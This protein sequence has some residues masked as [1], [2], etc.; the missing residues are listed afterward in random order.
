MRNS[1][2]PDVAILA[3]GLGSRL[4]STIG[5][6]PK[7]LAPVCG[8]PFIEFVLNQLGGFGFTRI[9]L[10]C[11][12]RAEQI[13]NFLGHEYGGLRLNY[14]VEDRP[15]GTAGALRAGL[16]LVDTDTLMVLNGDSFCALD[17]QRLIRFHCSKE[18]DLTL[19]LTK[20]VETSRFGTA[21]TD[22]DGRV[23][24]FD[25]TGSRYGPGWINA[26]V[27]AMQKSWLQQ[28]PENEF[29]SLEVDVLRSRTG[30]NVFGYKSFESVGQ[31]ID[32]GTP[33][34]YEDADRFFSGMR[35]SA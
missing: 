23:C 19:T 4:Q 3:G 31:F 29:I 33:E 1:A 35:P 11:G 2:L 12:Y 34:S 5:E 17:F 16:H 9:V 14:S 10:C 22:D 24:S 15:L 30:L 7:T 18:A 20:L 25:V 21:T 6:L 28:L 26:G 27:Y 13:R 8:R 32:I